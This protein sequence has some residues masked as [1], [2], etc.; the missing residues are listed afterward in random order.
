MSLA[1]GDG[2]TD[3]GDLV[4]QSIWDELEL[5]RRRRPGE[6]REHGAPCSD[7]GP[8][9]LRLCM[10][11]QARSH[12]RIA[13]RGRRSQRRRAQTVSVVEGHV[14][15][16][17]FDSVQVVEDE[18]RVV[19]LGEENGRRR[20]RLEYVESVTLGDAEAAAV[21]LP[22][23]VDDDGQDDEGSDETGHRLAAATRAV[24][25]A[26]HP[27]RQ[28]IETVPQKDDATEDGEQK[29]HVQAVGITMVVER[30]EQ[31]GDG[32]TTRHPGDAAVPAKG[33]PQSPSRRRQAQ[34]GK[35]GCH[36]LAKSG[37]VYQGALPGHAEERRPVDC[38]RD[39]LPQGR[40]GVDGVPVETGS[41]TGSQG[42]VEDNAVAG[43]GRSDQLRPGRA[44]IGQRHAQG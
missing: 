41:S 7:R 20:Q 39:M 34:Q 19:A 24:Q 33:D 43:Q 15:T 13:N 4:D 37:S 1:L 23:I 36:L 18:A 21:R 5:P 12:P 38:R 14:R 31:V 10:P 22:V 32:G 44:H 3:G 6:N 17:I 16:D 29:E 25:G 26:A 9:Q 42:Q 28:V 27:A 30:G 11:E 35:L 8:N 2:V 40:G